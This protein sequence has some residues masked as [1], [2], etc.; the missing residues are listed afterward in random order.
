MTDDDMIDEAKATGRS[1][2]TGQ[3]RLEV[4]CQNEML[5]ASVLRFYVDN[6]EV[7]RGELERWLSSPNLQ[8]DVNG[9]TPTCCGSRPSSSAV[10]KRSGSA[11]ISALIPASG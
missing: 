3:W 11:G 1:V 10:R 9:D 2:M 7:G 5:C 6:S 4:R 8:A